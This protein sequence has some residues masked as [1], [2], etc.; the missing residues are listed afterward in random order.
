MKNVNRINDRDQKPDPVQSGI[1]FI[2]VTDPR[3]ENENRIPVEIFQSTPDFKILIA[4]T[5]AIKKVI[6]IDRE[7]ILFW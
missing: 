3:F 2:F 5:I 4:T 1:D 7:S 6:R